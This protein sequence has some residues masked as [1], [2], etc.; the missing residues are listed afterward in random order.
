MAIFSGAYLVPNTI[1]DWSNKVRSGA[2]IYKL[3][4]ECVIYA[5]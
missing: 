5:A 1:L 2:F 3:C 4:I